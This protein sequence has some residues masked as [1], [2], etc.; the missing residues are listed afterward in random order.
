VPESPARR[1]SLPKRSRSLRRS[2]SERQTT[3]PPDAHYQR[4]TIETTQSHL[5]EDYDSLYRLVQVR[6]ATFRETRVEGDDGTVS[7]VTLSCVCWF[8]VQ[9]EGS[10]R[11]GTFTPFLW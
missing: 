2:A 8:S 10:G 7:G 5:Q 1:F 3:W 11:D 6:R 9:E 4:D